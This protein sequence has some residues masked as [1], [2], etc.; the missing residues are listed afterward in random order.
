MKN[1]NY[2]KKISTPIAEKIQ[3]EIMQFKTNYRDLK[4]AQSK[5]NILKKI[6]DKLSE[7]E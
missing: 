4:V 7:H 1:T 3:K 5:A 6:I 2:K